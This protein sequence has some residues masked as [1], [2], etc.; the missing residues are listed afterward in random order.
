MH[1][2]E[3]KKTF[4]P[5]KCLFEW[6]GHK[7]V[8]ERLGQTYSHTLKDLNN[9]SKAVIFRANPGFAAHGKAV[10]ILTKWWE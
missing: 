2:R 4:G 9:P 7:A 10:S 1:Q 5:F 3:L 6:K 8:L